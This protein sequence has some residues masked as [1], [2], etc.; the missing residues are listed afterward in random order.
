MGGIQAMKILY[1]CNCERPC[2]KSIGCCKNGG[3]CS[4][5]L[6]VL[7]SKNYTETPLVAENKNFE[8]ISND[9]QEMTYREVSKDGRN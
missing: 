7:Y 9:F 3:P 6:D 5:T 2:N 8:K 4:H 1:L